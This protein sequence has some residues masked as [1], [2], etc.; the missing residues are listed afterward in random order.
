MKSPPPLVS[1]VV[2]TFNSC[3][4]MRPALD[5]LAAQTERD[6][7]V[8]VSDGASSDA[9]LA[10]VET[11]RPRLPALTVLSRPDGGV[12]DAINQALSVCQGR[13]IYVLG[14]DD[15]LH[16]SETLALLSPTLRAS[17]AGVVYGDVRVMG[18]NHMVADD[19]RYGGPFTLARLMGQNICHQAVFTRADLLNR[20]GLYNL[21]FKVWAD[22]DIAQRAFIDGP[23]QWIDIVVA[24]YAPTGLS[25][26][27]H[28]A[29]F[30][31]TR[32]ARMLKLW[33]RKP[34]SLQVPLSWARRL[35]WDWKR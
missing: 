30:K 3:E 24:D 2:P 13:W 8:I 28:D 20:L 15:R 19:G 33:F 31:R 9:T 10:L 6:F 7:E 17:T 29:E 1:V 14:S 12:Y 23:A 32:R 18:P 22:W 4:Q 25:A 26:A 35:Y 11:Y 34:L 5:S 27:Q 16:A 21:R